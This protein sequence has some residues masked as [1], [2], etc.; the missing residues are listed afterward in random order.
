MSRKEKSNSRKEPTSYSVL[1]CLVIAIVALTLL[2]SFLGYNL[3]QKVDQ[4]ARIAERY[5][6]QE[7]RIDELTA[8][9]DST[10]KP[11]FALFGS[12]PVQL[13]EPPEAMGIQDALS[14]MQS[15]YSDFINYMNFLFAAI[16]IA[17]TIITLAF[18]IL[19][20][21]FVQKDQIERIDAH[22]GEFTG[23]YAEQI[24]SMENKMDSQYQRLELS[25]EQ[26]LR[27]NE[28]IAENSTIKLDPIG[29]S[30][31]DQAQAFYMSALIAHRN[32]NE[33]QALRDYARAIESDPN[34][35]KYYS[36]RSNVFSKLERLEDALQDLTKAIS[37]APTVAGFHFRRGFIYIQ[38]KMYDNA[39]SDFEE[40][41]RLDPAKSTYYENIVLLVDFHGDLLDNPMDKYERALQYAEQN[42]ELSP[43]RDDV[44]VFHNIILCK[45]ARYTEALSAID[46]A[47]TINP[48][49]DS[50]RYY[51]SK[52]LFE[53]AHYK[54]ALDEISQAIKYSPNNK[55][56]IALQEKINVSLGR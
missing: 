3:S 6:A 42:I 23:R 20:Y 13:D 11:T 29:E 18:P 17:V 47:I 50:W 9:V 7:Q 2:S 51:R 52:T 45:L 24:A 8:R 53:L 40:A 54:E 25:I 12:T 14:I 28:A 56:Y 15:Q 19:T 21:T 41:I 31:K 4:Y 5:E 32:N 49:D 36:S 34:N 37:L 35:A 33:T 38:L 10:A 1:V 48:S 22:Y 46:R 44:Y 16:G 39:F 55:E 43:K 30:S 27:V 26:G